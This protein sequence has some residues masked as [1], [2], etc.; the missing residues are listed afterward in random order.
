LAG[1]IDEDA[2]SWATASARDLD[3]AFDFAEAFV[4]AAGLALAAD[5][6]FVFAPAVLEPPAF[7]DVFLDVA[8]KNRFSAAVFHAA[9]PAEKLAG[10]NAGQE[11][12]C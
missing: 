5:L 10:S 2:D 8:I 11:G 6:G 1:D 3:L 4:A 9:P 12:S 7:F